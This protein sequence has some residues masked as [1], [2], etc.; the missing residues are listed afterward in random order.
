MKIELTTAKCIAL[1]GYIDQI[2]TT[3]LVSKDQVVS[4]EE[5][6]GINT[7]TSN[8]HINKFTN[9]PTGG[10]QSKVV[11]ILKDVKNNVHI[12]D[13]VTVDMMVLAS[14]DFNK[15]LTALISLLNTLIGIKPE[16]LNRLTDETFT[17]HWRDESTL[18]DISKDEPIFNALFNRRAY[19]S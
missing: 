3:G 17:T 16:V 10:L 1:E 9:L 4:I 12:T 18:V 8:I 15:K 2:E 11:K 6:L 13:I 19:L 5:C 7:I 14:A